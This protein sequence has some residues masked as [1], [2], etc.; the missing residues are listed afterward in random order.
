MCLTSAH[1]KLKTIEISMDVFILMNSQT[2]FL[3]IAFGHNNEKQV[4]RTLKSEKSHV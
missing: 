3:Q 1:Q 2:G 4:K